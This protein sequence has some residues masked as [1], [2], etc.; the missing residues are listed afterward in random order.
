MSSRLSATARRLPDGTEIPGDSLVETFVLKKTPH[1]DADP[2]YSGE[3]VCDPW[4]FVREGSAMARP[5]RF[6]GVVPP[7]AVGS[8]W[9]RVYCLDYAATDCWRNY[10]NQQLLRRRMNWE[11]RFTAEPSI[12]RKVGIYYRCKQELLNRNVVVI[13]LR[14]YWVLR[15]IATL[16]RMLFRV[17]RRRVKRKLFIRATYW[18]HPECAFTRFSG[19]INTPVKQRIYAFI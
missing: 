2:D 7:L 8:C 11:V 4:W 1:A 13:R 5:V 15:G 3:V 19:T 6:K 18:G 10:F 16:K 14:M 9:M 17:R 12:K